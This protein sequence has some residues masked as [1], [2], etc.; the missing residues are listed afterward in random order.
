M[1]LLQMSGVPG[2]GKSTVAAHVVAAHRAVAVDYD[3]VKSAILDAGFDLTASTKA[4]YEVMYAQA[5]HVLAQGHSVIMDSPCFWPRILSEGMEIAKQHD[6]AYKYI[7][8]QLDDLHLLDERLAHRPRLRTHR[9]GVN[10]PP[11]DVGD[12][13]ED[14]AAFF[15]DATTRVHRPPANYLQL[16]MHRPLTDVLPEV[17]RYLKQP[18]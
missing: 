15:R 13:L 8:C 18:T 11:P 10:H 14:G 16:D 6:A 9:R 7:E 1:F 4:A 12:T 5:R 17:D 3:V 2:S